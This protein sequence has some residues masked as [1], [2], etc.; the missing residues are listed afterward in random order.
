MRIS[1]AGP[2]HL[3]A[4]RELLVASPLLRRYGTTKRGARASLEEALGAGDTLVVALEGI[5]VL[6]VA[7]VIATRALDRSAY[8][9]LLLVS[10]GS[11]SQG[12]GGRLVADVERRARAAGCR[13]LLLLV[14][15]TNRRAR[16]FYVR[17][18]YRHFADLPAFVRPGISESLYQKR[19]SGR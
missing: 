19:L 17:H 6:G 8:L 3:G 13:H 7:W 16:A 10:E 4:I 9:L 11:R 1:R 14:T 18:G 2:E 5:E 15:T 12:I